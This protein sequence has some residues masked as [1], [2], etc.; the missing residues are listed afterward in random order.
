LEE[1]LA[2]RRGVGQKE[3]EVALSSGRQPPDQIVYAL[4]E[5]LELLGAL[6]DARDVLVD[7][8]HLA[9]LAEL[10]HQIAR[11]NRRL[12]F[13]ASGGGADGH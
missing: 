3:T 7:S 4:D 8:D 10:F 5:A 1:L 9:V 12:G 2:I 13:E 11:L 6:E